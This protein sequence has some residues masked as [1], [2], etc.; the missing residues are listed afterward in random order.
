MVLACPCVLACAHV[1]ICHIYVGPWD[2]LKCMLRVRSLSVR[3]SSFGSNL[4]YPVG[5]ILS[6]PSRMRP[7]VLNGKY[8]IFKYQYY[9]YMMHERGYA[10]VNMTH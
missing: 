4:N 5:P 10:G 1:F 3:I 8:V 9:D 7:Y 2:Y 6:Q